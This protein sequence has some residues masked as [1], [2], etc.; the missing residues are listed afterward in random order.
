[1]VTGA[2]YSQTDETET[3]F[4]VPRLAPLGSDGV[5]LPRP[6]STDQAMRLRRAFSD[7]ENGR[8]PEGLRDGIHGEAID[9]RTPLG[10]RLLGHLLAARYLGRFTHAS[11]ENLSTWL[12]CWSDLPDAGEIHGLLRRRLPLGVKPADLPP[13]ATLPPDP[14]HATEPEDEIPDRPAIARD[15]VLD[16]DVHERAHTGNLAAALHLIARANASAPYGALLRAEVAQALFTQNRDTEALEVAS[17]AAHMTGGRIGLADYIAG[18][19]AWRLDRP[20]RALHH[21]EAAAQA[22][23]ASL[24]VQ[25]AGA[26][27][28]AR[29][30]LRVNDPG[31][32]VP[33]MQRAASQP[34]TFYGLLA[35]RTLGIGIGAG[36]AWDR[37]TLGLAD[38]EAVAAIPEGLTAF[39]LLQVGQTDR[40]EAELRR[41]SA[42]AHANVAMSRAILLVADRAGLFELAAQLAG[43]IQAEDGRPRDY[44]RFPVPHLYPRNGF[45]VDPALVYAL[46]RLESNFNSATVSSAGARGLMQLMPE[47]AAEISGDRG[48]AGRFSRRLREPGLNLDLGQRY[49]N[50]LAGLEVVDGDLIRLLTCYNTG[51]G[52]FAHWGPA[53]VDHGDPL[54]FIE[55]IPTDE[56]RAYV[57]RVLTYNWIYA[58]RLHLPAP[59]LDELSAGAFPHFR[60]YQGAMTTVALH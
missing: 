25:A 26:F 17:E 8:I 36:F 45:R 3:A 34:R 41:L 1:M 4:A 32:Y 53:V 29:A 39:A 27:W 5:S 35:R 18:L 47:T 33:W 6:L 28:A 51:P 43:L 31:L 21:F 15:W 59:S 58:A 54:L 56:T 40:A 20:G 13:T 2:A 46:T 23:L 60:A 22:E 24:A 55:S 10:H 52:N 37:E 42:L 48:L 44:A 30:H 49:V 19:A 7:Q 14:T 57:Q 9:D 12:A 16:R 50:H 11:I 38:I